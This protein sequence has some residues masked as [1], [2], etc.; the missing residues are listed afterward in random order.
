MTIRTRAS[1]P[2]V[3][4]AIAVT[5]WMDASGLT[6]FS[7]LPLLPIAGLL[8]YVTGSSRRAVGLMLGASRYHALAVAYPLVVLGMC[9]LIS[10]GA[11]DVGAAHFDARK[12]LANVA[13][14]AVATTIVAML[15]EEGFF[16]GALWAS[17]RRRPLLF[18]SIAFALWHVSAVTLPT[19]FDLPVAQIPVFLVNAAVMGAIWGV[20]RD[21]SG[22]LVVSSVS[23]GVW[24][25]LAY[26]LF[27]YGTKGGALGIRHT[28][29][30]GPEVGLVGLALNALVLLAVAKTLNKT[31]P[32][33]NTLYS[34]A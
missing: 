21:I 5:T 23:H 10:L 29:I 32:N 17:R 34:S 8:W 12:A 7:A 3:I 22:S 25:G 28:A 1:V 9:A 24:N 30:Y 15:T 19:G 14:G 33:A 2:A 20:L 13:L 6:A 31:E 16:R 18:T 4:L 11:A 27:G 26:A